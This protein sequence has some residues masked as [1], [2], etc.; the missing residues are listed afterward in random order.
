MS[1]RRVFL[2][3][4]FASIAL[5]ACAAHADE[6]DVEVT[7]F[8][9]GGLR[10]AV[11]TSALQIDIPDYVQTGP[12]GAVLSYDSRFRPG[13]FVSSPWLPI[14]HA[15]GFAQ[16]I[17][18]IHLDWT[19]VVFP[20]RGQHVPILRMQAA[21]KKP[22]GTIR[23]ADQVI[24]TGDLTRLQAIAPMPNNGILNVGSLDNDV[25][26]PRALQGFELDEG[27]EVRVSMCDLVGNTELTVKSL[28]LQ[29]IPYQ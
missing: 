16:F 27:D 23:Y 29:S 20:Q 24:N 4:V 21:I 19:G 12:T 26:S 11:R 13:C 22:D 6:R 15:H 14:G 8:G 10:Y 5:F 9:E 25:L 1:I 7:P 3:S 28:V 18:E 17:P 2:G